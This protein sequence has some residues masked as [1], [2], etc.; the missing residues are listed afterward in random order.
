[1]LF[2]AKAVDRL[3]K[4]ADGTA[5]TDFD[6]EEQR[7]KHT[8]NAALPR[9]EWTDHKTNLIDAPGY[10]DFVG[11][12]VAALR[13]GQAAIVVRD[14][15]A[16]V[17]GRT[18]GACALAQGGV[19]RG[20]HAGVKAGTLVPVLCAA[21]TKLIGVSLL[22]NEIV[23]L[24]PGPAERH[25]VTATDQRTQKSMTV[26]QT[27]AAPLAALVFKTVADP[28]VGKLSYFRVYGGALRSDSQVFNASKGKPERIGQLFVLRGKHQ[29]PAPEIGS[30]DV[31]AVAKL[32]ET[33]TGDTLCAKETPLLL[34]PIEFLQPVISLAV[35][36]K[37]KGDEDKMGVSL[38]R[39]A[40]EDPTVPVHRPSELKQTIIS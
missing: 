23:T 10:P 17:P 34:A 19:T 30:G 37:S 31:G 11:E 38:Q 28:Y 1:M 12:G 15:V 29:E 13:P 26:A 5:T 3:G 39:L 40:E 20:L 14:A 2:T 7:R 27:P 24:L 8:I 21:A 36:P 16:G 32:A 33:A 25:E 9:R 35:E 18:A 4:A 6:P 22:L